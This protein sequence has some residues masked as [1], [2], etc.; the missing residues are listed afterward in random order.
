VVNVTDSSR[1]DG[2]ETLVDIISLGIGV[3]SDCVSFRAAA[4][5]GVTPRGPFGF[6]VF[7]IFSY[8]I[9]AQRRAQYRGGSAFVS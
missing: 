3:S 1:L 6:V 5:P 8:L 4:R 9:E 7:C 2:V